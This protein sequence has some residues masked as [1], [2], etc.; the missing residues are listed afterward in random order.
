MNPDD[1]MCLLTI[2]N[3]SKMIWQ[4]IQTFINSV[5]FTEI[6]NKWSFTKFEFQLKRGRPYIRTNLEFIL[7]I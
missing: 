2:Y 4:T 3:I 5:Y 1:D 7:F 6:Y